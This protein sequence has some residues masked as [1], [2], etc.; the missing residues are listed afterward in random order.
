VPAPTIARRRRRRSAPAPSPQGARPGVPPL[1]VVGRRPQSAAP[2][3]PAPGTR[4]R[5]CPAAVMIGDRVARA[6]AV[7]RRGPMRA[8]GCCWSTPSA[9]A[10]PQRRRTPERCSQCCSS[11]RLLKNAPRAEIRTRKCRGGLAEALRSAY[12]GSAVVDSM[13][14]R[15]FSAVSDASR[16]DQRGDQRRQTAVCRPFRASDARLAGRSRT[17]KR[18]SAAGAAPAVVA[19]RDAWIAPAAPRV[20][21]PR[22]GTW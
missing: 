11:T 6:R 20:L 16:S 1:L 19:A 14:H 3:L 22:F 15:T 5:R 4:V 21:I 12:N 18:E 17:G 2:P 9:S 8:I 10:A 13:G 7:F